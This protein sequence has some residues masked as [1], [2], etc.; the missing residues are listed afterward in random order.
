M[1]HADAQ[2]LDMERTGQSIVFCV[3]GKGVLTV[4]LTSV[5][6]IDLILGRNT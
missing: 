5:D 4:D 6:L 3:A 1:I 2:N